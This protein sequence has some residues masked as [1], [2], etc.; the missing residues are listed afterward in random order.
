MLEPVAPKETCNY[1]KSVLI[2]L[3]WHLQVTGNWRKGLMKS[4][5][6]YL[7]SVIKDQRWKTVEIKRRTRYYI[8]ISE[9]RRDMDLM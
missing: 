9:R 4:V 7:F 3:S 6:F 1:F 2:Q 8:L 5:S